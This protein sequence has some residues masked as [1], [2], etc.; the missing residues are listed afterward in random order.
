VR[1]LAV[2]G[3]AAAVAAWFDALN[4]MRSQLPA[5][6]RHDLVLAGLLREWRSMLASGPGPGPGGTRR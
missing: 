6:L 1:G 4:R 3:D 2:P 5:P